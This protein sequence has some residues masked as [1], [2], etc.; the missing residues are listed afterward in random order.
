MIYDARSVGIELQPCK[1]SGL[2][3]A[4]SF[5]A[6]AVIGDEHS[7]AIEALIDAHRPTRVVIDP[8]SALIKS[9]GLDMAEVVTERLVVLF[10][11]RSITAIFTAVSESREGEIESTVMRVS[12]IADTWIHLSYAAQHGER[13]RTLTVVKARGTAHSNQMREVLLSNE[14]VA[15]ADVYSSG[16][17]VLLG[18]ARLRREQ[19]VLIEKR[20]R[21]RTAQGRITNARRRARN[22]EPERCRVPAPARSNRR[23]PRCAGEA[24]RRAQ[25]RAKR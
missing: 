8:V 23:S 4:E 19:E 11:A 9:G 6:G 1:D 16:G 2:L 14:G 18:T 21:R 3:R 5:A 10:K 20:T 24:H 13:N 12:A 22:L 7:L 15:L 17:N 25:R